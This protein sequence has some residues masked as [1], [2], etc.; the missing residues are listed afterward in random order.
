MTART[1]AKVA[2]L[3][4]WNNWWALELASGPSKDMDYLKTISRYYHALYRKNI[5]V[6]IINPSAS[7]DNYELI[8]AP[9]LYM[10]KEGVAERL[11]EFVGKEIH[12]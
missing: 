3:F 2:I 12:L 7:F 4:D 11:T 6:D 5:S 8:V 10:T 1:P 9:M